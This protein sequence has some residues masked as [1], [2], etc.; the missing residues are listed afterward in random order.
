MVVKIHKT[1]IVDKSAEI[2]SNVEIAPY[3]IIGR[4]VKIASGTFVGHQSY[5]EYAEIGRNNYFTAGA[6]V[7]TPP[8][9]F[10]YK[11]EETKIIIGDNNIIREGVSL[12]RG[13]AKTGLT[14]IGNNCMFMANS[15]AGHDVIVG[16]GVILVNSTGLSGHVIVEDKAVISGLVGVHQ[17]VRIGTMAMIGA[18]SM[19]GMDILPYCKAHGDRAKLVGLNL[20]GMVRNGISRENISRVKTAY[21]TLFMSGLRMD[22]AIKKLQSQNICPEV[23]KIIE[24]CQNSKRGITRPRM[25]ITRDE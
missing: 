22:E 6:F 9:D 23:E 19:V 3:A 14:K 15:H 13:S 7:G 2:D 20:I 5:I 8:Q 24:F 16:D 12:H 4:K 10:S 1:A 25:R 18:G 11:G 21:K 17:F